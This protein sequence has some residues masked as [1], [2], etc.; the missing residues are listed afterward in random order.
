MTTLKVRADG[1]HFYTPDGEPKHMVIGSTTG[2]ERPTTIRDAKKYGWLPSVT[3]V[4]RGG[5]PT[6]QGLVI[7]KAQKLV[8]Q[9]LTMERLPDE[10]DEDFIKRLQDEAAR[11]EAYAPDLGTDV[12]RL[13]DDYLQGRMV[14]GSREAM[15]VFEIFK[16]WIDANVADVLLT[17][18][19]IT[20]TT[21]GYAGQV[22][23]VLR[24]KDGR[25][26]LFDWKTQGTKG[27]GKI[28]VRKDWQYQMGAYEYALPD[29]YA[30]GVNVV[31]PSD[32]PK[33]TAREVRWDRTDLDDGLKVFLHALMTYRLVND[34]T[35]EGEHVES[36]LLRMV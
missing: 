8:E 31:V 13:I 25:E 7:W 34:W 3:T 36:P 29:S 30:E 28:K 12:H 21:W 33:A 6:S 1:A 24:L 14:S 16:H 5:L 9:A 20:E 11:E 18:T 32:V 35:W 27:T 17:E 15:A 23:A 26:G 10:S 22:D 19:T 2:R 4:L